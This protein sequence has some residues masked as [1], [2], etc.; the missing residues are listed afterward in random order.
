MPFKP[1][2]CDPKPY[3]G[4]DV[5]KLQRYHAVQEAATEIENYINE[6]I[7]SCTDKYLP[8][9]NYEI[10]DKLGIPLDLVQEALHRNTND[11]GVILEISD[12]RIEP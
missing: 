5:K 6:R 11:S 3:K 1:F 10:S 12:Y 7:E 8:L 2:S 9:Q 4:K